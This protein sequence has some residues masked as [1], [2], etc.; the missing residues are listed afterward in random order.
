MTSAKWRNSK[1]NFKDVDKF[2]SV[3]AELNI[4]EGAEGW[5]GQRWQTAG[6]VA[7]QWFTDTVKK[8]VTQ[9]GVWRG[10]CGGQGWMVEDDWLWRL[11]Q[12]AVGRNG[13]RQKETITPLLRWHEQPNVLIMTIHVSLWATDN[14]T[15]LA[16]GQ[17]RRMLTSLCRYVRLLAVNLQLVFLF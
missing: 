7:D 4:T 16:S 6:R 10:V 8:H 2:L 3:L 12:G 17:S 5:C 13:Q 14:K 9:A 15:T 11:V 1:A